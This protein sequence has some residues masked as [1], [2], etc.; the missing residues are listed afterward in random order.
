MHEC[1]HEDLD[2]QIRERVGIGKP[3]RLL[4]GPREGKEGSD[5]VPTVE[6]ERS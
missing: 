2:K 3:K 6:T 1:L 5:T 4:L